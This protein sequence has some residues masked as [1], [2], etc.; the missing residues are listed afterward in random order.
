[1]NRRLEKKRGM[2][3]YVS[4]FFPLYLLPVLNICDEA[5]YKVEHYGI[6]DGLGKPLQ[7]RLS[8]RRPAL[9]FL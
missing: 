6:S 5:C 4:Y 8:F 9:G 1:M 2:F 7:Q 3:Y